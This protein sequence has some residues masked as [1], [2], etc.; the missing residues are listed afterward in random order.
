MQSLVDLPPTPTRTEEC[1]TLH[2]VDP[3]SSRSVSRWVSVPGPR[4]GGGHW[5]I[6]VSCLGRTGSREVRDDLLHGSA[7]SWGRN[8]DAQV[9]DVAPGRAT[10]KVYP[11]PVCSLG[12]GWEMSW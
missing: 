8:D 10:R 5:W 1:Q 7:S 9:V 12:V 2:P 6:C 3:W 4:G 11:L